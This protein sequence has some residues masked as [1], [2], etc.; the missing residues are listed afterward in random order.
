[1]PV[2]VQS[3][4]NEIA[5]TVRGTSLGKKSQVKKFK[6]DKVFMPDSTQDEVFSVVADSIE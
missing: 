1:M 2:C 5:V 3:T 6:F 4:P